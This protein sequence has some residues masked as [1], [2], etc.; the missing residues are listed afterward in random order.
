MFLPLFCVV[1]VET[2]IGLKP[3]ARELMMIN[4]LLIMPGVEHAMRIIGVN[5]CLLVLR[6]SGSMV[7]QG[8]LIYNECTRNTLKH[9][10]YSHEWWET[11]KGSIF[12]VKPS[13]PALRGPR[14]GLAVAPAEK[15]SLLGS[16]FDSK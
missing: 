7:L 11:L 14:G 3:A 15:A 1:D 12:C 10:T 8:S 6:L 9:T 2:S 5:L 13:I 16:L 4:R